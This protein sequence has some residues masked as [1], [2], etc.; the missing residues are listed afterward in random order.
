M[1]VR[2]LTQPNCSQKKNKKGGLSHLFETL[3]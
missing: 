2:A 3:V 1:E